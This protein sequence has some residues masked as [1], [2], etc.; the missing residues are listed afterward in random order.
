MIDKNHHHN[1][2]NL[3]E[4]NGN[5]PSPTNHMGLLRAI[6]FFLSFD[7]CQCAELPQKSVQELPRNPVPNGFSPNP[8]ILEPCAPAIQ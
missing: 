4:R 5:N 6:F 1:R 7:I 3:S 2:D 8:G